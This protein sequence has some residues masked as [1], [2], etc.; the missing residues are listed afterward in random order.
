[1]HAAAVMS[2]KEV[3]KVCGSEHFL[4]GLAEAFYFIFQGEAG[5]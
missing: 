3:G 4:N 1:M 2:M 5:D